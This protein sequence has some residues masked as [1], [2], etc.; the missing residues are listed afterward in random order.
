MTNGLRQG[1]QFFVSVR[2]ELVT[3]CVGM[4]GDSRKVKWCVPCG[5][6]NFE[7]FKFFTRCH[8]LSRRNCRATFIPLREQFVN[9]EQTRRNY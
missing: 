4:C 1:T 2:E 5:G 9:Y 8:D 6:D 3:V 7:M